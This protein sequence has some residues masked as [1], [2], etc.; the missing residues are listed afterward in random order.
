MRDMLKQHTRITA[1]ERFVSD[2]IALYMAIF[3]LHFEAAAGFVTGVGFHNAL[4]LQC[5]SGKGV[6]SVRYL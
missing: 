5:I 6:V 4:R 3:L 1:H 2:F